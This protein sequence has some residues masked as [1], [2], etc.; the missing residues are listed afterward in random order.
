MSS[1]SHRSL[2]SNFQQSL[3]AYNSNKTEN[4]KKKMLAALKKICDE[5]LKLKIA[6]KVQKPVHVVKRIFE[7]FPEKKIEE[8]NPIEK[9]NPICPYDNTEIEEGQR[10]WECPVCHLFYH[11]KCI[12][13]KLLAISET[14][15]PQ[16]LR[17]E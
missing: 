9:K 8:K 5:K 2:L 1:S 3:N 6:I 14:L 13:G 16:F 11:E 7:K 4:D 10:K 12:C 15:D 17:Y